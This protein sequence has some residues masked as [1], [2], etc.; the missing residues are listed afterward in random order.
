MKAK[1]DGSNWKT[2]VPFLKFLTSLL[3]E[4]GFV[5]FPKELQGCFDVVKAPPP[6]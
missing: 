1:E 5:C 2:L 4:P 6:G 3:K